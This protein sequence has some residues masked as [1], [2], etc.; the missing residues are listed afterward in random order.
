MLMDITLR[1]EIPQLDGNAAQSAGQQGMFKPDPGAPFKPD[2]DEP[3]QLLDGWSVG[4]KRPRDE[5]HGMQQPGPH[6]YMPMQQLQQP[7]GMMSPLYGG[8]GGFA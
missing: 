5:G 6:G 7:H 2:P 1:L 4:Q 8:P 3:S